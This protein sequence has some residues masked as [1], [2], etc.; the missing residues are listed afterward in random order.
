MKHN[1]RE[2][3][4][5]ISQSEYVS[6]NLEMVINPLNSNKTSFSVQL[7][8]SPYTLPYILLLP[9]NQV[10]HFNFSTNNTFKI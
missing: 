9:F 4:L 5:H 2:C 3:S 10:H 7:I 1:V 8:N 6:S